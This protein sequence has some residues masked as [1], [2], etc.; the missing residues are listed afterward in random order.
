MPVAIF[1]CEYSSFR[2]T[3]EDEHLAVTQRGDVCAAFVSLGYADNLG[4]RVFMEKFLQ[5]ITLIAPD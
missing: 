2:E 5:K 4:E 1:P 3:V